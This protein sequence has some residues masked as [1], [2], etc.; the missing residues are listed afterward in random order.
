MEK[1]N[2]LIK[3]HPC[4]NQ[5]WCS[6]ITPYLNNTSNRYRTKLSPK[7]HGNA[8]EKVARKLLEIELDMK[9]HEIGTVNHPRHPIVCCRPDGVG[10]YKGRLANIDIKCPS[11]DKHLKEPKKEWVNQ[12]LATGQCCESEVVI[13]V[14]ALIKERSA[15][16]EQI[17]GC[18]KSKKRQNRNQSCC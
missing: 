6:N 5:V 2:E 12:A 18:W 16:C 1:L 11:S 4:I 10:L 14:I 9:I 3:L 15:S 7:S 13:L 17:N 8:Y